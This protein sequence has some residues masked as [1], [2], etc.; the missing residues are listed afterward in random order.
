MP[1]DD[2]PRIIGPYRFLE[3]L[4]AGAFASVYR[5]ERTDR[6]GHLALKV[7]NPRIVRSSSQ[8]VLALQDEARILRAVDSP[9]VVRCHEHAVLTGPDGDDWHVLALDFVQGVTVAD[10]SLLVG[11]MPRSVPLSAVVQIAD[12]MLQGLTATHDARDDE[13][14]L[15]VVHRDLKPANV[16]VDEAGVTKI[17]DLGIAWA[18][19][20]RVMTRVGLTKGTPP[21][22]SPE[23]M[24][25]APAD[26]R[27][28]LYVLGV[29]LFDLLAASPWCPPRG[30][31]R[32]DEAVMLEYMGL[33]LEPRR[34]ELRRDI[35][36]RF[37]DPEQ[38]AAQLEDLLD[39][40]LAP[41][42]RDRP[43]RA[44]VARAHLR[45]ALPDSVRARQLLGRMARGIRLAREAERGEPDAD[46]T[47]LVPTKR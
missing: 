9:H 10:L 24:Q 1:R 18:R 21:W 12:D 31:G 45:S 30:P 5:G 42:P 6:P 28:D 4:G 33:R 13:G 17:L 27:C 19:E 39:A 14:H 43:P 32:G 26:A 36:A 44:A 7:L 37:A 34:G 11:A 2:E 20:R 8:H 41:T 16:M 47:Q 38:G 40:L 23:Q 29:L 35:D 22:M 25:G 15:G 46:A 3:R